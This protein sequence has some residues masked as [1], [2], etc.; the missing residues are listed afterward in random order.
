MYA[1]FTPPPARK[2]QPVVKTEPI[3]PEDT[4]WAM[5]AVVV[6]PTKDGPPALVRVEPVRPPK[7]EFPWEAQ[8][9][10]SSSQQAEPRPSSSQQAEPRPSS[11]QQAE[12][13][14]VH[15]PPPRPQQHG[16]PEWL[17]PG[18][19]EP[20]EG[21]ASEGRRKAT[22]GTDR[23]VCARNYAAIEHDA[24]RYGLIDMGAQ[25]SGRSLLVHARK[26]CRPAHSLL[27]AIR[28]GVLLLASRPGGQPQRLRVRF[29]TPARYYSPGALVTTLAIG[30]DEADWQSLMAGTRRI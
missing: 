14:P 17:E 10:A 12:P 4:P 20:A 6:P 22:P 3:G 29:T 26:K 30:V 21:P 24:E 28:P 2:G 25:P 8:R 11:S 9:P 5:Q 7:R 18:P 27:N 16:P 15:P 13:R 23:R 19:A 1:V